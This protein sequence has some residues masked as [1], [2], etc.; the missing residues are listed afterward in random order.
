MIAECASAGW[1]NQWAP[2]LFKFHILGWALLVLYLVT[3]REAWRR[4]YQETSSIRPDRSTT[5]FWLIVLALLAIMF[6]NRL[7]NL[8]ALATIA[9]RC[10]A[11]AEGWYQMRRTLQVLL[12]G[13]ATVVAALILAL[14]FLRR[15]AFDERVVLAGLVVLVA[16]VAVRSLSFHWIDAYLRLKI[17]GLNFNGLTEGAALLPVYLGTVRGLRRY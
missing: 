16:F 13:V 17:L 7:F 14:A 5:T 6:I 2:I 12:I 10:A 4:I 15:R 11:E 8:Q 9:V 3:M 1:A